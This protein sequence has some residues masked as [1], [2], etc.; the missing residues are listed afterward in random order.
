[1]FDSILETRDTCNNFIG[2]KR[3][4]TTKFYFFVALNLFSDVVKLDIVGS[5]SFYENNH[6]L[7][8]KMGK[9]A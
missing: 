8:E 5:H 9:P 6:V 1:M 2:F 7:L 3:T 4:Y